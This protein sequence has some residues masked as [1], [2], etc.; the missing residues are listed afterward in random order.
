MAYIYIYVFKEVNYSVEKQT[1]N[2]VIYTKCDFI[3]KKNYFFTKFPVRTL[4]KGVVCIL[5]FQRKYFLIT[6]N[7]YTYDFCT[8][9]DNALK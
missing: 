8:T 4:S 5:P 6:I 9:D 7:A 3:I 2:I 1:T